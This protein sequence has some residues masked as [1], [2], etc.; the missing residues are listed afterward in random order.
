[1]KASFP[2]K[3]GLL[4]SLA[5]TS[6][7]AQ[8]QPPAT[9][10]ADADAIRSSLAELLALATFGSV[11]TQEQAAQ[12]TRNG[13]DYIV[14]LPLTGLLTPVDA[15]VDAVAHPLSSGAWDITSM[16][17][18]AAGTIESRMPDTGITRVAYSIG[19]QA[20]HARIDP[21]FVQPSSFSASL[22]GVRLTSDRGE[23]RSEQVIERYITDGSVSSEAAGHLNFSSELKA[24][25]WHLTAHGP[26][27]F[28]T[29]GLART[30][31]GHFSV[32]GLDRAQGARLLVAIRALKAAEQAP[33][34]AEQPRI[35]PERQSLGQQ[36]AGPQ[37]P[38]QQP[39]GRRPSGQPPLAQRPTWQRPLWQRPQLR[40]IADALPG[41]L[42]KFRS[43]ETLD[44]MRFTVGANNNGALGHMRVN[45]TGDVA[46]ERLTARTALTMDE[47]AMEG[48]SPETAAYVP[49]HLAMTSAL[50]GV[51]TGPLTALLR[52]ATDQDA[53]P[54]VLQA[55]LAALLSDPDAR[56][57]IE[58][59]SFD[60]GPMR[61]TGSAR[62]V[63]RA[64]GQLG[65]E[66]NVAATG[67][68]AF[69][70]QAQ[71]NPALQQTLPMLFMA[72]GLGRPTGNAIVWDIAVGDGPITINGAP[73]GQPSGRR[74]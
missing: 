28:E 45:V 35:S 30:V 47:F 49:H 17:F 60:S 23:I 3:L 42:S 72:K 62:I 16:T 29:G 37:A 7:Q 66:I 61:V 22:G 43:E 21:R 25:N 71:G 10:A 41:L 74:R 40:E 9:D 31:S 32:D 70:A 5:V 39:A 11:T 51:R 65:G 56:I 67:I 50:S 52:T 33:G 55:Q 48:L 20:V 44:D 4:V 19:D 13:S 34:A 15:A 18:P 59:V 14:R 8:T 64:N 57:G 12:V 73:F 36:P 6:A 26:N 24:T 68:D 27:G 58:S 69:I 1:M 46:N 54:V 38:G 53:D 63:P 2:A